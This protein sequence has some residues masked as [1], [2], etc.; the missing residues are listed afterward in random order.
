MVVA[1]LAP[2]PASK[3]LGAHAV[4]GADPAQIGCRREFSG[5]NRLGE[6]RRR[7][8]VQSVEIETVGADIR[9]RLEIPL[10]H[11][12]RLARQPVNQIDHQRGAILIGKIFEKTDGLLPAR[13]PALPSPDIGIEC[14]DADGKTVRARFQ[15]G[16]DLVRSKMDDP[17][18]DCDLAIR[19]KR[20]LRPDGGNQTSC[21]SS[22]GKR[23]LPRNGITALRRLNASLNG[24]SPVPAAK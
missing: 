12:Q 1:D 24:S 21:I 8:E 19:R 16:I 20:Q 7:D 15:A 23:R 5:R 2:V 11:V 10:P 6:R 18:L 4:K 9:S 14:L 13:T 17:P 22:A 3:E